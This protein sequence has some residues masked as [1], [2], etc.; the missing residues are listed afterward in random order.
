MKLILFVL[1]I[2]QFLALGY[3]YFYLVWGFNYFRPAFENRIG[4]KKQMPDEV[5][6]KS[7]LD[8]VISISNLNYTT[9]LKADY[10]EI[11]KLIEDSYS[12]NSK[13]LGINYPNGIRRPKTMLFSFV[14]AKF[15]VSGYFGPFFNEVHLNSY[16]LPME[17]PF[18]LAHEK[19]HQF[20][21]ANEAE[22]NLAAYIVCTSSD[23]KRLKYSGNLYLLLYFIRDAVYMSDYQDYVKKIDQQV[24]AD[25]RSR[26]KYYEEL[27]NETLGKVQTAANNAYLKSNH[28][29]RG[30]KNYNQV[31][32]LVINWYS[33]N[34]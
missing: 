24:I 34:Y 29:E 31:V 32:A 26:R 1:R 16:L 11:D 9:I 10:Q 12:K 30:V 15:G 33:K 4:W 17:Y 7:V 21:I 22:A 3:S 18:L 19:A 6:F 8:S 2:A 25:L 23:D 20:G 13:V 27:Q 28:V 14:Y 5:V